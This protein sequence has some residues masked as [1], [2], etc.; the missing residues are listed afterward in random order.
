M[1]PIRQPPPPPL[2]PRDA[3]A[4]PLPRT[5]ELAKISSP[6]RGA[7]MTP[8][9]K[10]SGRTVFGVRI[11]LQA[12]TRSGFVPAR[13]ATST[14]CQA[15]SRCCRKAVSAHGAG[16]RVAPCLSGRVRRAGGEAWVGGTFG[17]S[18]LFLLAGRIILVDGARHGG[19]SGGGGGAFSGRGWG[20]KSCCTRGACGKRLSGSAAQPCGAAAKCYV[21][22]RGVQRV[23]SPRGSLFLSCSFLHHLD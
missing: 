18:G 20:S 16:Q 17:S 7:K 3:P 10:R 21:S 8:T 12:R 5:L 23:S 9:A 11:G 1:A 22:P 13:E 19:G 4:A 14:Y 2:L 6:P 15:F